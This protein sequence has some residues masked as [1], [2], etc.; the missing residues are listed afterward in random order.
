MSPTR[1]PSFLDIMNSKRKRK[2]QPVTAQLAREETRRGFRPSTDAKSSASKK[3]ARDLRSA[4]PD[5]E[6]RNRSLSDSPPHKRMKKTV[7]PHKARSASTRLAS[8][9]PPARTTRHVSAGK[10]A[11]KIEE[12]QIGGF[13]FVPSG[14]NRLKPVG[15]QVLRLP[16]IKDL[17]VCRAPTQKSST[18]ALL[19]D[20]G[21]VLYTHRFPMSL[22]SDYTQEDYDKLFRHG[23]PSLFRT[24]DY[25]ATVDSESA[26]D[27]SKGKS[28]RAVVGVDVGYHWDV[29]TKDNRTLVL[30]NARATDP[31]DYSLMRS[32]AIGNGKWK[33]KFIYIG[34]HRRLSKRQVERMVRYEK[35]DR[36]HDFIALRARDPYVDSDGD[37][38]TS[39]LDTDTNLAGLEE[40]DMEGNHSEGNDSDESEVALNRLKRPKRVIHSDSDADEA[41]DDGTAEDYK[42]SGD[43][44]TEEEESEMSVALRSLVRR[45]GSVATS[46]ASSID[47]HELDTRFSSFT[48][49]NAGASSTLPSLS[50]QDAADQGAEIASEAMPVVTPEPPAA[51]E[52]VLALDSQPIASSSSQPP[53]TQRRATLNSARI[54]VPRR[55]PYA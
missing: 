32:A 43:S 39:E 29:L 50:N 35:A 21:F 1:T 9:K 28:K 13:I 40:S 46:I 20:R 54:P 19:D 44:G 5:D 53:L 25:V 33:E 38:S 36:L 41:L 52:S 15:R 49:G 42:R 16:G 47:E 27:D 30:K 48:L 55:N 17:E 23:L 12:T 6:L 4:S 3:R 34:L 45:R 10:Q 26:A 14:I 2:S 51:T 18:I 11:P 7:L 31:I 24:L 8:R 22:R 37:F